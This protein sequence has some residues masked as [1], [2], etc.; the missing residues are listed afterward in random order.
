MLP[1]VL[2]RVGRYNSGP[3]DQE[4]FHS[5]HLNRPWLP[6]FLGV[7]YSLHLQW[8]Y[9]FIIRMS[10][11]IIWCAFLRL[12]DSWQVMC[13][14]ELC[15]PASLLVTSHCDI[16]VNCCVSSVEGT[17]LLPSTSAALVVW[18]PLVATHNELSLLFEGSLWKKFN[19]I[20][21]SDF[22]RAL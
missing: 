1:I 11:V 5:V 6:V 16:P 20:Y 4:Q 9:L 2:Q 14:L 10:I 15:K 17:L 13:C 12:F 21:S 22:F 3:G 19:T 7:N 8:L 18:L